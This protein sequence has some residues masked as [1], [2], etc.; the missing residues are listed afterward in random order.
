M[1]VRLAVRRRWPVR[2]GTCSGSMGPLSG[3]CLPPAVVGQRVRPSCVPSAVPLPCV[4]LVVHVHRGGAVHPGRRASAG[5]PRHRR[6]DGDDGGGDER[7][8]RTRRRPRPVGEAAGGWWRPR[9]GRRRR[10]RR[11]P[12]GRSSGTRRPCRRAGPGCRPSR[13]R[14]TATNTMPTPSPRTSRP[15]SRSV[16]NARIRSRPATAGRR[17]PRRGRARR[18]R[19][20][21]ATCLASSLLA[22][23]VPA[24]MASANG[25]N[26][27]PARSAENPSTVWKKMRGQEDGA[28]EQRGHAEHDGRAG[29][30]GA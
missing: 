23:W 14:T 10:G 30:Q 18:R 13:S 21:A 11:R 12:R 7:R 19:C 27:T 15:G 24:V 29:H 26:A 5:R 2:G 20:C 22:T 4:W 17:R 3:R 8:G 9:T 16:A 25:R 28:D 1:L 6:A